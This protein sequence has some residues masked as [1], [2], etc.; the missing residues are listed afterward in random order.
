M[1]NNTLVSRFVS[2][3]SVSA[4]CFSCCTRVVQRNPAGEVLS[5]GIGWGKLGGSFW[6]SFIG[7]EVSSCVVAWAVN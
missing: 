6:R 5:S 4:M 1:G 2:S 3:S 7:T